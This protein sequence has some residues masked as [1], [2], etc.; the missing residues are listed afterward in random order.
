MTVDSLP[1][2]TAITGL[3]SVC[4]GSHLQL[5]DATPGGVWSSNSA[6]ASVNSSGLVTGVGP[7]NNV[8]IYYKMPNGCGSDSVR[9]RIRIN[10]PAGPVTG[11]SSLCMDSTTIFRDTTR[12]VWSTSDSTIAK[13]TNQFGFLQVI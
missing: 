11:V 4:V 9:L 5:S 3:D 2:I 12:G 8:R 10:L 7:S 6:N 1:I 13:F